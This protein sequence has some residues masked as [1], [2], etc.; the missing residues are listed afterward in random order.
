MF[1]VKF[2]DLEFLMRHLDLRRKLLEHYENA[3]PDEKDVFFNRFG[4][5][6]AFLKQLE[7]AKSD[8]WIERNSIPCP[9]CRSPIQVFL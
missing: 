6:A 1:N 2:L 8:R 9:S 5:K 7:A 3:S 4:G